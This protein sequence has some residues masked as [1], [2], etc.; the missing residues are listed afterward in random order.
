MLRKIHLPPLG[1]AKASFAVG[2]L[3]SEHRQIELN[4]SDLADFFIRLCA[5]F[6]KKKLGDRAVKPTAESPV[7]Q[8]ISA[9][10]QTFSESLVEALVAAEGDQLLGGKAVHFSKLRKTRQPFFI[11]IFKENVKFSWQFL[12]IF[13][14]FVGLCLNGVSPFFPRA[15]TS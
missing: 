9:Q 7:D 4:L 6:G 15:I 10:K 12:V 2:N 1:K 13:A 3:L 11:V 5:V 8:Q 14:I